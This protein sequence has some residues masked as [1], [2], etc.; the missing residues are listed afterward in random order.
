M[1]GKLGDKSHRVRQ[2]HVQVVRDLQ[3]PGGGVQG[4]KEP[5]IGRDP[6]T[7]KLIE[8]SGLSR[9]GVAHNGHH[10]D[11][12][13]HPPFPLDPTDLTHL[14][15]LRF[16]AGDPLPDVPPVAFQLG[17][18]GT[19]GADA[20]AL[21]G[22]APAHAGEPGQKILILGQ[23]HLEAALLGLCPLGKDIHNE[24]AAVQHR[25]PN[26]LFQSPDVSRGQLVI[27]NHHGR[28]GSFHQHLHF[29]GLAFPNEAVGIR[30]MA[31]LQHFPGAEAPCRLQQSL[32]LLQRFLR[33]R[34]LLGKAVGVE[35]HQDSPL[36]NFLFHKI[37]PRVCK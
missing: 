18:A 36:L 13:L 33:S 32:Q 19:P 24:R 3:L 34:L 5:V 28:G 23:L 7:G 9:V 10:G 31:I 2:D 22:K 4:V 25:N 8:Q 16:Q 6:R 27:K 21:A 1:V 29:Q 12:I 15:Q 35:A 20:A 26:D 17:F 11:G 30:H 37:L 14:L